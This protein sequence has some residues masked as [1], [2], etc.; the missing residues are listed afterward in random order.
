[1]HITWSGSTSSI[2]GI[3]LTLAA[4]A[5]SALS[6]ELVF[7][8]YPLQ[9]LMKGLR[10]W[11]AIILISCLFG[12]VHGR[13]PGATGLSILGTILAGVLLAV[14]YLKTRSIWFPCGIHLGW[15]AGL[16][17]VLGYPMS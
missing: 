7:R 16:S 4:L 2:P 13:N 12:L 11:G 17:M 6:E 9:I 1:V 3:A 8:G 14:A 15:N 10:P 5:L